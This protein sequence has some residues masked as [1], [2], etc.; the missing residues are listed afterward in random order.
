MGTRTTTD[1]GLLPPSDRAE[2]ASAELA[3]EEVLYRQYCASEAQKH[4]MSG[5][6]PDPSRGEPVTNGMIGSVEVYPWPEA[7]GNA[8]R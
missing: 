2:L 1:P 6:T 8:I 5:F 4:I 3:S 7:K